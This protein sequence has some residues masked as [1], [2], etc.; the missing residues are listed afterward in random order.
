MVTIPRRLACFVLSLAAPLAAFAGPSPERQ[1]QGE[2]MIDK[3]I[4]YLRAQQDK[5]SGGWAVPP[6]GKGIPNYPAITGLVLNGLLL[7]PGVDEKDPAVAAGVRYLLSHAQPDGGIYDL[8][9]PSYNTAISLSALARV[10]TPEAQARIKPAQDFLKNQQWGS[11]TPVGMK[12]PGPHGTETPAAVSRDHPFYGGLGYGNRGRPDL[13]NLAFAIQAWHDS[14]LPTDDPAFQRAVVFLQRCQM[15]EKAPDGTVVNDMPYAKGSKQGGFIYATGEND[16]TAGKGQSFAGT[17]EESMD[18]GSNVSKLRAYGSTTYIG[19]KSYI[20]AGLSK[21]DPRVTAAMGW[22]RDN[23]TLAENPGMG[24]DG[25]YYFLIAMA[26]ALNSSGLDS[27]E[28]T[29]FAPYRGVVWIAG[30]PEGTSEAD[31]RTLDALKDA[32]A[33]L[34]WP[35]PPIKPARSFAF[36]YF[37]SE[38]KAQAATKALDGADFKGKPIIAS[39]TNNPDVPQSRNWRDDMIEQFARLQNPD[40]SFRSIDDRWMEN[41]PV[42]ISAYS[43]VALQHAVRGEGK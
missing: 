20:Y 23:Y 22:I 29:R 10:N 35:G 38:D 7:Q 28:V 9:L 19:F 36:A 15:L 11:A 25:Y 12:A 4:A 16:Q 39:M 33:V 31:L 24:T 17:I 41:N 6:P 32:Q 21:D 5:D 2:Q 40:G 18:D 3:A 26:R 14:G 1:K 43:L 42:L 8:A 34:V 37:G 13:S 30:M 27:I